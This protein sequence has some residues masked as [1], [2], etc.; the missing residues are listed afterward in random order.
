MQPRI[1]EVLDYLA[2][3]DRVLDDTLAGVPATVRGARPAPE[4]WSAAEI[5]EHLGVVESAI[6]SLLAQ[7]V[8]AARANGLGAEQATEPVVPTVPIARLL[9][10]D[11]KLVASERSQ[12]KPGVDCTAAREAYRATRKRLRAFVEA[13][14]GLALGEV[15][16][17]NPVL[18]PLNVYQ[19]IVF[20]G[21]HEQR[22]AAQIRE[23]AAA[24]A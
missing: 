16:V 12:P 7:Q 3:S 9:D 18:G 15:I 10:R 11:A 1:R 2:D 6:V 8:D 20:L 5:V 14:D 17:Q 19:W 21:A 4:R 24:V 22:H 23:A 13:S